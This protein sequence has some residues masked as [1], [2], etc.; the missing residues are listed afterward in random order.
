MKITSMD[1]AYSYL[2]D[3]ISM[4]VFKRYDANKHLKTPLERFAYFLELLGNP[5]KKFKSIQVT[6]TSGKG[7]TA[8]YISHLLTT[9]GY[10]T[11]F[12][13]SPHLQKIHERMQINGKMPTNQEFIS[14]L[15]QL[16][17]AI[18]K[19]AN[20]PI[21][22]PSYFEIVVAMAF[23]HFMNNKVDVAVVEVG[24]EGKFDATNI[25]D[26]LAVILTNV[27]LDHT[28]ILG[29]TVEQ[30]AKEVVYVIKKQDRNPI[31]IAGELQ[32]TVFPIVEKK[33]RDVHARLFV[34]KKNFSAEI[35][36]KSFNQTVFNFKNDQ[37]TIDGISLSLK[38][39]YQVDNAAL[40]I[41]AIKHLSEFDISH[42]IMRHAFQ[43]AFF[44]GRFEVFTYSGKVVVI[45]GAHNDAKMHA[46]LEALEEYFPKEKK[47]FVV[48]FKKDKDIKTMIT[49]VV[50]HADE[51]V[52]TTFQKFT[53]QSKSCGLNPQEIVQFLKKGAQYSIIDDSK[54]AFSYAISKA[55]NDE[56]IV[57]TGSL[58]LIGEMRDY[59]TER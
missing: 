56:V 9:A 10:K 27:S 47:L 46:F 17:P 35:V 11:G 51:L 29:E 16:V 31:V 28:A 5:Q 38:G 53:D 41:E 24:L 37:N 4:D 20:E 55:K 40:A 1:Q 48:G 54:S 12:T 52:L 15:N 33:S 32:P 21:G 50:D 8:Y 18:A 30:I 57:I 22:K 42:D 13:L 59:L 49:K 25:L 6:G 19:M 36:K 26:P 7:S 2:D 34:Y 23:M 44:P 58:Y 14:V 3:H 43:T 45:D 39:D